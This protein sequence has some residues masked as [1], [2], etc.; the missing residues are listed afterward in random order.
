MSDR[1]HRET[2]S[3]ATKRFLTHWQLHSRE[4]FLLCLKLMGGNQA[5][6]EDA[7]SQAALAALLH[8]PPSDKLENAKAWLVRVVCNT[9]ID[10]L[11]RRNRE[12][13]LRAVPQED[14]PDGSDL[15]RQQAPGPNPE[16]RYL[17]RER[18]R[19]LCRSLRTLPRHL[20]RPLLQHTVRGLSYAQMAKR[21]K[22]TEVNLRK[23][24]QDARQL[25]RMQ[26]EMEAPG[27][28]GQGKRISRSPRAGYRACG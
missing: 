27:G 19:Q 7:L 6:A 21:S 25:L 9:S 18:M 23:R 4:L 17:Q 16:E 1:H 22:L 2:Q 20:R 15:E 5:D 14:E 10:L 12:W 8:L 24:V 13:D 11:R 3:E 26:E 28:S